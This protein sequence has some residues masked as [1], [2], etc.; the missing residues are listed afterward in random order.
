M[1]ES[2]K[3]LSGVLKSEPRLTIS[4]VGRCHFSAPFT[5][6]LATVG[7][8]AAPSDGVDAVLIVDGPVAELAYAQFTEGDRF[9]AEGAWV[10]RDPV[11]RRETVEFFARHLGHDLAQHRYAIDRTRRR[12]GWQPH[13]PAHL[14]TVDWAA[15][16]LGAVADLR[17]AAS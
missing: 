1:D 3:C 5:T 13:A 15:P 16:L 10:L 6:G 11:E 12:G 4:P 9:L 14:L 2:M 7:R 8:H 17:P